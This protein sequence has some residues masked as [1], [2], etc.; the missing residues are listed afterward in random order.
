MTFQQTEDM[1]LYM[2]QRKNRNPVVSVISF[3][4]LG[5]ICIINA[6]PSLFLQFKLKNGE[7]IFKVPWGME[8]QTNWS[9][10]SSFGC[11]L[12]TR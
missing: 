3:T 4:R 10:P 5:L 8:E 6:L 1:I 7:H 2:T 12:R 11:V 9:L